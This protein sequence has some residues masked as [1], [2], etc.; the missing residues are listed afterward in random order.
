MVYPRVKPVEMMGPPGGIDQ[1]EQPR[2][3][4]IVDG[5]NLDVSNG[6]WESREGWYEIKIAN[7]SIGWLPQNILRKI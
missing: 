1:S 2:P 3:N 6:F 7:G 4:S 5:V